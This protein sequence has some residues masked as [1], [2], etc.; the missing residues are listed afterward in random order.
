MRESKASADG[1]RGA[2][3]SQP[4][5]GEAPRLDDVRRRA[6]EFER[7]IRKRNLSE[8][9]AALLVV[10][11]FGWPA[12]TAEAT[13]A[14][15]GA[16]LIIAGTLY[17]VAQLRRRG[18]A[19]AAPSDAGLEPCLDFHRRELERQR[20]LLRGIW[21]WYLL[22]LVPGLAVMLGGQVLAHP[23][24]AWRVGWFALFCALLF[25]GIG[26]INHRAAA[27]L[28]REIDQLETGR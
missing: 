26:W 24:S 18:S 20:R 22:P 12:A 3:R 25:A 5:E 23:E 8:Y 16:A 21:S 14:R 9:V 7:T 27:E 28:E 4:A 19:S 13:S 10:L 6:A 2:W 17:V 1:L 15:V 11:F